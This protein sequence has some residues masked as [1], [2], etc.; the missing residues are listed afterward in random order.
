MQSDCCSPRELATRL[1][2]IRKKF[3]DYVPI[4][5]KMYDDATVTVS[6]AVKKYMTYRYCKLHD[7][8]LAC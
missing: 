3:V 6:P 8:K 2:E 1:A 5:I 4:G 7:R